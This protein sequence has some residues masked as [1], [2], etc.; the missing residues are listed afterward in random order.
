MRL[1]DGQKDHLTFERA[2]SSNRCIPLMKTQYSYYKH[3]IFSTIWT[4]SRRIAIRP[5]DRRHRFITMLTEE[6]VAQKDNYSIG[7]FMARH[8]PEDA[9]LERQ[10]MV[11]YHT[12][13]YTL[14]SQSN[15]HQCKGNIERCRD[16]I[17]KTRQNK[18]SR[19]HHSK[20]T[21]SPMA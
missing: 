5:W 13:L 8:N 1:L 17:G 19:L 18:R 4:R 20:H 21:I 11:Y 15:Y 7:A 10:R 16:H 12:S 9:I 2:L 3:P 14:Y 6:N